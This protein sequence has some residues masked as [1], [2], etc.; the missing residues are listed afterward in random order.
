MEFDKTIIGTS[1]T[2]KE[3][4]IQTGVYAHGNKICRY[5]GYIVGQADLC[6]PIDYIDSLS[7]GDDGDIIVKIMSPI[8]GI[9]KY[10]VFY[11][12]QNGYI[13]AVIGENSFD[14]RNPKV[15]IIG[16]QI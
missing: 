16:Q 13:K 12:R 9:E 3:D 15:Q 7:I 14:Y 1:L 5:N 10:E 8:A 2:W 6:P 11:K 4:D